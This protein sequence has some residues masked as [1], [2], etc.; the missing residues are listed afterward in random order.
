MKKRRLLP[1]TGKLRNFLFRWPWGQWYPTTSRKRIRKFGKRF[2]DSFPLIEFGVKK[3]KRFVVLMES[4]GN[5]FS[6]LDESP[7]SVV[8]QRNFLEPKKNTKGLNTDIAGKVVVAKIY[9]GFE[10]RNVIVEGIKG[11]RNVKSHLD[12]FRGIHGRNAFG[13]LMELIEEHAKKTGFHSI[14]I[15]LPDTLQAYYY[16]DKKKL[17]KQEIE[18]IRKRMWA[19]YEGIAR[20][21]GY[22]K[23]KNFFVK[24]L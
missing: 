24:S 9:L 12:S 15:R 1:L 3:K 10:K 7:V 20:T 6:L 22:K 16:L 21:R 2:I 8:L 13:F 23:E 4:E 19:L 18:R 11:G 14:K 17:P 5:F